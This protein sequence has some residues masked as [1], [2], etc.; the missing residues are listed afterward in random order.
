MTKL[1]LYELGLAALMHDIGK[2]RVPLDLLQKLVSSPTKS[3]DGWRRTRGSVC[4]PV[5]VPAPAGR[6]VL[7]RDDVC[8]EHHMKI[9]LTGYPKTVRPRQPS[10]LSRS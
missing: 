8:H 7:P 5:P 1:Q 2:S 10:V 9:D 3:G 4:G 6:V